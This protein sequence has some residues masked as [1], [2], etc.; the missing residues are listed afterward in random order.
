MNLVAR[1][2][3][4]VAYGTHPSSSGQSRDLRLVPTVPPTHVTPLP[5]GMKAVYLDILERMQQRSLTG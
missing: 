2:R 5:A 4:P 1:R 3:V